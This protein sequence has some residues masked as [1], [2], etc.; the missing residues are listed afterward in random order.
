MKI[1]LLFSSN[2]SVHYVTLSTIKTILALS[3]HSKVNN[4]H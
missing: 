1:V 4:L 2:R 3:F